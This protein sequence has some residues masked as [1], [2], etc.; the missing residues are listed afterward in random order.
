MRLFDS[1]FR[2]I[3][4]SQFLSI[5]GGLLAGTLLA[6]YTDQ[7]LLLPGIFLILPGLLEMRGNISGTFA[8][9]LSSGLYLGVINPKKIKTHL[10]KGNL[11]ATFFLACIVSSVLG[12]I[13][14][15]FNYIMLG[16]VSFKILFLPLI[17]GL[18]S[19]LIEIPLT[20]F[21]T[22]FLFK[23]G[24]DPDDIMGPFITSTGD[25]ISILSLLIGIVIL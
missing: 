10:I 9:R 23:K 7:I 12:C 22:I 18:I 13:A 20:L 17:A 1:K 8:S 14:F 11:I 15:L 4:G 3:L 16:I 2:E 19:N 25:I 5:I 6:V 21:L 24:Y